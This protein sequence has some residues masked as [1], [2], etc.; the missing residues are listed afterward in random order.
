MKNIESL[1]FKRN[2]SKKHDMIVSNHSYKMNET[3][4]NS[5]EKKAF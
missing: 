4:T 1:F 2:F 5:Q 3:K